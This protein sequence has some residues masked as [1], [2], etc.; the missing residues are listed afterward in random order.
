MLPFSVAD[1]SI[2]CWLEDL[3]LECYL[4]KF[5]TANLVNVKYLHS[6]NEQKLTNMDITSS[7]HIK[8]ILKAVQ[9]ANEIEDS[10]E[11][12]DYTLLEKEC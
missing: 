6:L 9:N 4:H 10:D 8:K 2:S 3:K 1:V 12:H 5:V 7:N 11:D